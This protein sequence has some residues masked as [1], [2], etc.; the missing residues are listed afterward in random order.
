MT[1][2]NQTKAA[3]D[4][5]APLPALHALAGQVGN[6]PLTRVALAFV[7]QRINLYL[8]FGEPARTIQLDRWRRS[9]VFLPASILCRIR[10]ESN[11]YGTTRWQLMVMQACTPMDGVQRIPGVQPGARLLLH[12]EGEQKVR[13][14]LERVDAIEALGIGA[15]DVSPAYWRTLGNRLAAR[16]PLP[17][18]TPER[19][20]AWLAGR[21]L[22]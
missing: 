8:R 2:N 13:A 10:W 14:T 20:A 6:V 21:A 4:M 3:A 15:I 1:A 19:H 11:D 18:Y 5:A 17:E 22:Q 9:A 16:L 7:E 12:V